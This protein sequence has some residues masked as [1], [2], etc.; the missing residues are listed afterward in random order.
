[1][2]MT[3]GSPLRPFQMAGKC[4]RLVHGPL[5]LQLLALNGGHIRQRRVLTQLQRARIYAAIAQRSSGL[6]WAEKSGLSPKPFDITS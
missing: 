2:P 3:K 6:I 5:C 4:G 1:M